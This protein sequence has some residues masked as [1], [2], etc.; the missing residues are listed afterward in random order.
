MC[1]CET[2]VTL[3][4]TMWR[5]YGVKSSAFT[6]AGSVSTNAST[7]GQR[8]NSFQ[9]KC[10]ILLYVCS[11]QPISDAQVENSIEVMKH[12]LLVSQ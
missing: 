1:V 3:A 9:C 4:N 11:I 8:E 10:E 6:L 2:F 5:K 7:T 12:V